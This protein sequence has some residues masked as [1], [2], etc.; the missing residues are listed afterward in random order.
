MRVRDEGDYW[1][2]AHEPLFNRV[3]DVAHLDPAGASDLTLANTEFAHQT[4]AIPFGTLFA[5]NVFGVRVVGGI[6]FAALLDDGVA[7]FI[8]NFVVLLDVGAELIAQILA[9][10]L[11]P[12]SVTDDA[13]VA[14]DHADGIFASLSFSDLVAIKN[15][16]N[17]T[18]IFYV[19]VG[20]GPLKVFGIV[21]TAAI[22]R[23]IGVGIAVP[24]Q[25][26][27]VIAT[28]TRLTRQK[29]ITVVGCTVDPDL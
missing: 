3:A 15:D 17:A 6:E 19:R 27:L 23:A 4:N 26:K 5:G 10:P 1:C 12:G 11:V 28:I 29:P 22:P 14:G 20:I 9:A 13:G 18:A 7:V 16:A 21:S 25:D 2:S 24:F 8:L